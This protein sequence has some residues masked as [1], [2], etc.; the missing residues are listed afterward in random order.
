MIDTNTKLLGVIGDPIEHSLSPT[1]HNYLIQHLKLNCRY[2]AFHIRAERL[3]QAVAG[4]CALGAG[5]FNVTVPPKQAVVPLLDKLS[6]EAETLGAVNTVVVEGGCGI[7][8]NT[9]W[10][11][12]LK[13]LQDVKLEG[14]N[15]V[16]LGAGGAAQ[17]VAYALAQ[18]KI[19]HL[20]IANRTP[21]KT[22]AL[23]KQAQDKFDF[24]SVEA[25]EFDANGLASAIRDAALLVNATSVGLWPQVDRSPIPGDWLHP[26]LT[27]YDLVYR[28]LDTKL[29]REAKQREAK[30]IDGLEMLI[31][32]GV[33]ALELWTGASVSGPLVQRLRS[34]L[35]NL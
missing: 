12:F 25:V 1:L 15:V 6:P 3:A 30:T 35:V 31:H 19:G 5:G 8:H 17:G 2:L 7:G 4:L 24:A 10:I 16:L 9:D 14:A 34:Y 21:E 11:G 32:Q 13:P 18:R 27:V 29:L 26:E 28:P 33:A 23:V 22:E 20:T